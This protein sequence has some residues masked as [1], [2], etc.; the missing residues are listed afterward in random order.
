MRDAYHGEVVTLSELTRF[1]L[2][3]AGISPAEP[4]AYATARLQNMAI[5]R[6]SL[7]HLPNETGE[8]S[9]ARPD[10]RL[11]LKGIVQL[12][13]MGNHLIAVAIRNYNGE[14]VRR[15][16]DTVFD[17]EDFEEDKVY[18]PVSRDKRAA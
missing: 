15:S 4:V 2:E 13:Q 14:M 10:P 17:E 7:E 1:I 18:G 12:L 16:L 9:D 3:V 6:D 8:Y 5:L 11:T